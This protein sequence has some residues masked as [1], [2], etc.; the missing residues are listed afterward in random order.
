MAVTISGVSNGLQ[1]VLLPYIQDSIPTQSIF[2]DQVKR[3][4]N[5][6]FINNQFFAPLRSSKQSGITN[7]ANDASQLVSGSSSIGLASVNVKTLTGT[8]D[9]TKLVI[10]A[11]KTTKGAVENQLTFQA[12]TLTKDF[13]RGINRQM[14]SDG[15]G[16][17]SE[18]AGSASGTTFTIQNVSASDDDGRTIDNFG[19][20]NGDIDPAEYLVPGQIIGI[21]SAS[22]SGVGTIASIS[23]STV[24]LTAGT[25]SAANDAIY[26]L[27]GDGAGAGTSEIQGVRAALSSSTGTS[28]YA[29]VA[30][31]TQTWTPQFDNTSESLTLSRM[32]KAYIKARKFAMPGDRY[33]IF[34]NMTLYQKYGDLLTAMRRE[35]NETDLLG[36]WTGISFAAGAGKVGVFLD[37]DVP[38]GE[39]EIINLDSWTLCQVSD[40][41]WMEDPGNGG[42][43][44]FRKVNYLTYQATMAWFANMLCL[45]PAA[46]GRLV[47]KTA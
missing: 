5:T 28:L 42:G 34:V 40:M 14:F 39:V 3:N 31:S 19:S 7:L 21:G 15:I 26:I 30:R 8:F 25:A 12:K 24:T 20:V 22:S 29:N 38:D 17:V 44:L 47:N 4:V 45:A 43:A 16:V 46:N 27:D 32:E 36:G 33:A 1:K 13:A 6:T 9:I 41:G 23:G 35:V 11:T 37:F 18:V 2:F 10:E